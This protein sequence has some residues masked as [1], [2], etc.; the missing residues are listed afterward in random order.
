MTRR[1]SL[2]DAVAVAAEGRRL[3]LPGTAAE[4]RGFL[5]AIGELPGCLEKRS[6]IIGHVAGLNDFSGLAGSGADIIGFFPPPPRA[7]W[8]LRMLHET[9]YTADRRIASLAP[10]AVVT[11]VAPPRRDGTAAVGLAADYLTT[12]LASAAIRIA[13]VNPALP[14]L[15][16][17]PR[18]RIDDFTHVAEWESPP[19]FLDEP[20]ADDISGQIA[21]HAARYVP[22]GATIQTG[23]GRIPGQLL[24][25]LGTRRGLRIHSGIVTPSIRSLA[26]AGALAEGISVTTASFAGTIAFYDWLASQGGMRLAPVSFTHAPAALARLNR[27]VSVNS[28][29][30]VDLLGQVNA[31]WAG[32]RRVSAPGGMPDFAHAARRVPGGIAMIALPACDAKSG[33]SRIVGRLGVPPTLTGGAVDV[34][35]TE[36]G[37]ADLRGLTACER[38]KAIAN[39]AAPRFRDDLSEQA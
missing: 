39:I 5:A 34:V 3:F 18:L 12:A 37:A 9:Y 28:A 38:G 6:M 19:L 7:S 26:E 33:A 25:N 11:E 16:G 1:I 31:E 30:E 21:Q 4:P 35:V 23:I 24:K 13:I 8:S 29:L 17:A 2:T 27:L 22:D 36:Y 20:R 32:T 14:D 15:P 10:D